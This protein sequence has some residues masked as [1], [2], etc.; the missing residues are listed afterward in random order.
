M[1]SIQ[2]TLIPDPKDPKHQIYDYSKMFAPWAEKA[3]GG[4]ILKMKIKEY[5]KN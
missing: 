3:Q 1:P 2:P 4:F 5:K